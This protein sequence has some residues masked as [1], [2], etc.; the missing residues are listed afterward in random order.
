MKLGYNKKIIIDNVTK[1]C[2]EKDNETKEREN[3]LGENE[4]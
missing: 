4:R 2:L 1:K 3:T